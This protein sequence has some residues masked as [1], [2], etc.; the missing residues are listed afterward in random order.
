MPRV[1]M[2]NGV[3]ESSNYRTL[4]LKVVGKA[5]WADQD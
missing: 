2:V 5:T 4:G 1:G 3:E